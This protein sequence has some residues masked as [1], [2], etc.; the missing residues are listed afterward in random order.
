M[1]D[2]WGP[3]TVPL[4]EQQANQAAGDPAL[5]IIGS[6][7]MAY[8]TTDANATASWTTAG[9][10]PGQPPVASVVVGAP[11]DKGFQFNTTKLPALFLWRE[12]GSSEIWGDDWDVDRCTVK[13]LWVL[14]LAQPSAQASRLPFANALVKAARNGIEL[15]RT[16]SWQYTG[17]TDAAAA[18]RGS[19]FYTFAGFVHF[20]LDKWRRA[21]VKVADVKGAPIGE[22]PAV[23]MT[24][25]IVENRVLGLDGYTKLAG[26]TDTVTISTT[27]PTTTWVKS[28][29]YPLGAPVT[30]TV[31]NTFYYQCTT[32]GQT[33]AT[34]PAWPLVVG[35]TVTDGGAVWTCIGL[36]SRVAVAGPLETTAP[37]PV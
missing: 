32:P 36:V 37:A 21:T 6:F 31:S 23:E 19:L 15:G 17:D 2:T 30:P 3:I 34:E 27:A 12:G 28:T 22:F 20:F 4:A 35:N 9:V 13:I 25:Q 29:F 11:D 5:S 26:A 10:T 8:L 18:K 7:L 33:S 14:P 24:C 16:P 1:T